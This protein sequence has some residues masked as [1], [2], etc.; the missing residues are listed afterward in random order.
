[1]DKNKSKRLLTLLGEYGLIVIG[2]ILYVISVKSFA[3]PMQIP[4]GGVS[5][6]A[7]LTN[8]LWNLPIG[9]VTMALNIPL[10]LAG[11]KG[12]GRDFFCKTMFMIVFSS[13]LTDMAGF[14]PV[15]KG[16][17]LLAAIFGGI[18]KG[19]GYG[20]II[21]TGGTSGGVDVI[22]KFMYKHFSVQMGTTSMTV[23]VGVLLLSAF[24]LGS[25]ELLMY[26]I[27]MQYA[28][29]NMTDMVVYGSD[30]QKK[31]IIVTKK[32]QEV[33]NALME[34]IGHGVTALEGKGMYTGEERLVLMCVIRPHEAN[35]VKKLVLEIDDTAFIMLSDVN[36]VLGRG[37]KQLRAND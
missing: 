10:L 34:R 11:F 28:V 21:R 8:Y 32:P 16:D 6:I 9:V 15:F 37:F 29:S 30:H 25:L 13:I 35:A 36:E 27:I 7:L 23:N 17:I 1:M 33:A 5:G 18:L 20:L 22:G 31:T 12:L 26:G 14:L 4:S 2:S 3:A 19:I 24:G